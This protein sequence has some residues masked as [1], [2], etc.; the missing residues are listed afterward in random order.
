MCEIRPPQDH[1]PRVH[2]HVLPGV[3][4]GAEQVELCLEQRH[5]VMPPTPG[6]FCDRL[7]LVVRAGPA[8]KATVIFGLV[9]QR[10][11]ALDAA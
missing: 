3:S 6:A 1:V 2:A 7:V 9:E 11:R 8:H 10:H 5:P 4:F